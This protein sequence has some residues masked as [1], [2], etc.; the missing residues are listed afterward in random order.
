MS[1]L[2]LKS[3]PSDTYTFRFPSSSSV[4][5]IL[6]PEFEAVNSVGKGYFLNASKEA[7]WAKILQENKS[8]IRNIFFIEKVIFMNLVFMNLD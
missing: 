3:G 5:A 2:A 8:V 1:F 6:A 7:F 4:Q